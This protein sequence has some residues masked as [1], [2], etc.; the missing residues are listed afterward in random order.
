MKKKILIIGNSAKEY[1]LAKYLSVNNEVYVAPGSDTIKD[2]AQCVDIRENSVSEL[3][4]FAMENGIDMTIPVSQNSLKTNIV[5]IFNNNNQQ[6]FAPSFNSSKI[7]LD[8]AFAKKT[9]YKLRVSTP[10]FGI[11]EKQNMATDYIKNL[12]NPFVIKTNESSSAVILTSSQQAKNILDSLFTEKNQKVIIEDYVWGTPF[13]FYALTD[14]YKAIPF[15]SS[16]VYKHSLEGDGGQLTSGMGACSPNYKLSVENEYYLMDNVIYPT[17]EYLER[18]GNPYLGILGVN[19]L[20][21]DDGRIQI[22]GYQAFMQDA[23]CQTILNGL[24]SDI[25]NLFESCVIGSFSD[26]VEFIDQKDI[27]STSLVLTCKNKDNFQ[28][29]INGLDSLE[30]DTS[31]AFYPSIHKNRYLEYEAQT[32]AVLVLT[33]SARTLNSATDKAY[34]ESEEI[35]FKGIYYRKDICRSIKTGF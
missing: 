10:K 24:D 34:S 13:C 2:F 6:I 14:G 4:E 18:E 19:G 15:G 12:K 1:S 3:L 32:G 30:E 20:I 35:N 16:I 23:D 31:I 17:L 22:L 29:I 11:F 28:N 8:K 5:E 7:I 27:S 25:L 26:E 21:T 9:L 33:T